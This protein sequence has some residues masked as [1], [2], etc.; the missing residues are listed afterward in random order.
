[1]GGG[2]GSGGDSGRQQLPSKW[3]GTP[4]LKANTSG[5]GMYEDGEGPKIQYRKN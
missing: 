1:V 2:V 5:D 3:R 4:A